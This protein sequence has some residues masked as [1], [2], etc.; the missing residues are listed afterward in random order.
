MYAYV[1]EDYQRWAKRGYHDPLIC[2][3]HSE[4][5]IVSGISENGLFVKCAICLYKKIIGFEEYEVLRKANI[6]AEKIF[7]E[8]E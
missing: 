5:Y 7:A 2:P 4:H 1:L 6:K 8:E 3:R